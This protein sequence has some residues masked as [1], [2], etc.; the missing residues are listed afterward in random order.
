VTPTQ[1]AA[2]TRWQGRD[3]F[4]EKVQEALDGGGDPEVMEVA[5]SLSDLARPLPEDI[6]VWRGI[7]STG[8]TF[9]LDG[10]DL[11]AVI[12]REWVEQRFLATTTSRES[13]TPEFT[14]PGS[15]PAILHITARAGARAIWIPSLGNRELAG[16]S[17]LLFTP[18]RR[19]RTLSM[20]TSGDI[21]VVEMEVG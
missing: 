4:Y 15:A 17:E 11:E 12:G 2:V 16:Q 5:Q 6:E 7:R 3:R 9:G 8:K 14:H 1:R 20:D 18:G 10:G 21:P 13:A 19:V